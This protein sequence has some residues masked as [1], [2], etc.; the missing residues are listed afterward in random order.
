MEGATDAEAT[1]IARQTAGFC[2]IFG[3]DPEAGVQGLAFADVTGAI[4]AG[5]AEAAL[6]SGRPYARSLGAFARTVNL[7]YQAL[8]AALGPDPVDAHRRFTAAMV[9]GD[10][11][12][13]ET[14]LD[15]RHGPG[16]FARLFQSPSVD[17][18]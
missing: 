10:T 6:A 17:G 7:R 11:G 2:G 8:L 12:P 16:S 5:L 13:L 4:T 1:G 18:T 9:S 3:M 15:A 14:W